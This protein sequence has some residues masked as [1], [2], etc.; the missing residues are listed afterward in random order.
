MND[1]LVEL[2]NAA[3][4][5][6][7]QPAYSALVI[8]VLGIGLAC[9]I[10]ML[11]MINGFLIRPLPFAE[12]ERL[13]QAVVGDATDTRAEYPL[14]SRE[15]ASLREVLAPVANT[16]AAARS[17]INLSD[18][19][20][21]Q[22]YEGAFVSANLFG[23]LGIAPVMGRDFSPVD[24][25]SGAPAVLMLSHALWQSRYGGDPDIIGR[26]VR[27]D[28]RQATVIGV[29]PEGF[30][31]PRR[32]RLWMAAKLSSD[33]KPDGRSYRVAL[34]SLAT[35][36]LPAISTAFEGWF[37]QARQ[38]DPERFRGLVPRVEK[39]LPMG[40]DSTTRSM[41]A[42][43]L[44]AVILVLLI[45]CAN[46]ANLMLT[47]ALGRQHELAVRVAI[48]ANFRRIGL[49]LLSE[50]LL[51][52]AA[53]TA[54]ALV[55]ANVALGWQQTN[56]QNAEWGPPLWLHFDIDTN[57]ILMALTLAV[58]TAL[59]ASVWPALRAGRMIEIGLRE[60]SRN[61]GGGAFVRSSRLL[62]VGEIALSCALLI[63]VGTMI[64][65]LAAL[66]DA[67]LG[68][69]T[70]HLLTARLVLPLNAFPTATDQ[71]RLFDRLGQQLRD[72]PEVI[73]A[74]VGTAFPGTFF[75]ETREIL[76]AG[77]VPGDQSLPTINYAAVDD[78]FLAAY[79]S[80]LRKGRFF[81]SGDLPDSA[82]VAVVDQTFVDRYADG[83]SVLGRQF[84]IDPH[85]PEGKTL[86]VVGVIPALRLNPPGQALTPSVLVPLRQEP[87]RVASI[88]VRTRGEALAF[89]PR[90]TA[91][92]QQVN[93][94]TPLYWV[95]DY[96]AVIRS[97]TVGERMIA[98]SFAAFGVIALVLAATG[99][100][101]VVAY[102]VGQRRKEIGVRRAL[103]AT[104]ARVIRSLVS[105]SAWQFA[106]GL[107]I[108]LAV[109]LILARILT[110]TL[111]SIV[112]TN[113]SMVLIVLVVML[114]SAGLACIVPVRRAL[115]VDPME[116]LRDE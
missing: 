72:A 27:V 86:T 24:E 10:F 23:V 4:G 78:H 85:F 13:L 84:R 57:V 42:L 36:D 25:Q 111:Q 53:A 75:N 59:I 115:R 87:F 9:V 94:D 45:A 30:S 22:R 3:R 77:A 116:A 81:D 98:Q 110:R 63:C 95:R 1:V 54:L 28:T 61:P 66:D 38:S 69:D 20:Q 89:A 19:D 74:T 99:L 62:M 32:E 108:G 90:L 52:T 101:G 50:S 114:A 64:R 16:A 67:N 47:R 14:N 65:G 33:A 70:R 80:S 76:P 37:A 103:G 60:G 17:T 26:Q 91:L 7:A 82:R 46:A 112:G 105:G 106:A 31:Y 15:F 5:L 71:V 49:M 55:L 107:G 68:V 58:V 6:V 51:L 2:R 56:L 34:R 21:A 96:A 109:G 8:G 88:G 73:D 97:M 79:G 48:G 43:M 83:Q 41:L 104:P 92:M 35:S 100:F 29:M 102:S 11:A 40:V 18:H 12:P 113:L 93:A 44:G 39:L